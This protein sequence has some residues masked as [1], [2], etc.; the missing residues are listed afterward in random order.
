MPIASIASY[1]HVPHSF[2]DTEA[3]V[4]YYFSHQWLD[5]QG[6]SDQSHLIFDDDSCSPKVTQEVPTTTDNPLVTLATDQMKEQVQQQ[7]FEIMPGA[8]QSDV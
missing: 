8:L 2:P 3:Q 7:Q 6:D 4:K 1:S 5:T